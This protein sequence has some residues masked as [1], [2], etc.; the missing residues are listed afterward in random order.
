MTL[1]EFC[2]SIRSG[3][4]ISGEAKATDAASKTDNDILFMRFPFSR[5]DKM[6]GLP[7]PDVNR[8]HH[9]GFSVPPQP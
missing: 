3:E 2:A 6:G 4:L 8:Y 9:T 1:V 5:S 7:V